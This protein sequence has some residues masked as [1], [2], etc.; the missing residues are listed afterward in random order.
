MKIIISPTKSLD[1]ESKVPTSLFTQPQFLFNSEI[2]NKKLKTLSKKKIGDLMKISQNL[3][4]LNYERNQNWEIPFTSLNSKQAVYSFTGEVFRAIDVNSLKE[5][6][7]PYT[8]NYFSLFFICWV[9]ETHLLKPGHQGPGMYK[10]E[11]VP[12]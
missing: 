9:M 1:F 2:L 12:R 5:N 11:A 4:E 6:K 8:F 3:S 10:Y 7:I